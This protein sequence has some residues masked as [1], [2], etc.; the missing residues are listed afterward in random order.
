[1]FVRIDDGISISGQ[2]VPED[3]AHAAAEGIR[4][5]VNNRPDDEAPDQPPGAE[6]EAAARAHGIGYVSIPI[7]GSFSMPQ[8]DAMAGAIEAADGP[9]L[10]FCR[11]GTRSTMLWALAAARRGG[12]PDAIAAA[13]AQ[14]GYDVGALMPGM[15]QLAAQVR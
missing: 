4:L 13:A 12:D 6:I 9:I 15:R 11:S 8:I 14:A 1:M 10:A 7:Q 5:L 3:V 2:L